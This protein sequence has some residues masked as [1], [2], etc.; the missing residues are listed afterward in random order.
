TGPQN[1]EGTDQAVAHTSGSHRRTSMKMKDPPRIASWM[2]EH[3]AFGSRNEALAGD[4]LEELRRGR[5]VAWYW[6][7]ALGAR[8]I[9][10]RS[11]LRAQRLAI[12]YA[13]LWTIPV[14]AFD[15]LVARRAAAL[16]LFAHRW[17]LEWPYSTGYDMLLFF[18]LH[19]LYIGF[20]LL[21]YFGLFSLD[22][23]IFNWSQLRK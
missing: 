19:F 9:G 15:V 20:A 1:P 13:I 7:Q 2:L 4:L 11:L 12:C 23:G 18:G 5:S 22:T 3:L 16:P 14:H 21:L 6:G 17:Q 10:L 8:A